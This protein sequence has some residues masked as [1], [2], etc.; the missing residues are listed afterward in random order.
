ME[1]ARA[2]AGYT[3]PGWPADPT[4]ATRHI[5]HLSHHDSKDMG[6]RCAVS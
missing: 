6:Y 3:L 5:A 1:T 4:R 2:E